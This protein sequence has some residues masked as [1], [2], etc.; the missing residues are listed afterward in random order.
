MKCPQCGTENAEH[1]AFCGKCGRELAAAPAQ[2]AAPE[3]EVQYT[4]P[5]KLVRCADDK[6]LGGVCA[7]VA[8]YFGLDVGLVRL[9]AILGLIFGT[10]TF[11]I[12]I[13]LWAVLPEV[14]CGPY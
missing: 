14:E 9:L 6:S 12:Y 10:A 1:A 5:A 2:Q 8:R 13:I 3:Q 7:G 4:R 11:W